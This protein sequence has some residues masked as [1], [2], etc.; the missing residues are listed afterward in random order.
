M[1]FAFQTLPS[2]DSYLFKHT[3]THSPEQKSRQI[4]GWDSLLFQRS[5]WEQSPS[6][7][8]MTI[9]NASSQAL[10]RWLTQIQS[11]AAWEQEAPLLTKLQHDKDHRAMTKIRQSW[12]CTIPNTEHIWPSTVSDTEEMS[13]QEEWQQASSQKAQ[14]AAVG[15]FSLYFWVRIRNRYTMRSVRSDI[16]KQGNSTPQGAFG[17]L[18][19]HHSMQGIASRWCACVLMELKSVQCV[20][21]LRLTQKELFFWILIEMLWSISISKKSFCKYMFEDFERDKYFE[22]KNNAC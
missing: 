8:Q 21:H 18:S 1:G 5:K 3:C 17:L 19:G 10:Q 20:S 16:V 15:D 2:W 6:Q 7:G 13:K 14:T 4:L 22:D 12:G 9:S 11:P